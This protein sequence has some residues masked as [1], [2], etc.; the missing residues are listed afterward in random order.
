[1]VQVVEVNL[2]S[3]IQYEEQYHA[4]RQVFPWGFQVFIGPVK[5][6]D[7]ESLSALFTQ[8]EA[9]P[10]WVEAMH[11]REAKRF[12]GFDNQQWVGADA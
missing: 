4:V 6:I 9:G 8:V 2:N 7:V 3:M 11:L 5:S 10:F 12:E 1:M